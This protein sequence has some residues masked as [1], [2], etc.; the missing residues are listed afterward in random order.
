MTKIFNIAT[1]F[2]LLAF[3]LKT[4]ALESS[5]IMQV[6]ILKAYNKNVLVINRGLEDAI[7]KRDHI[8]MKSSDGFIARG[9]CIKATMLTSHWKIYRVVRPE[10][11]SKDTEYDM[12]SINQSEVPPD[13]IRLTKVDL[14]KYFNSYGDKEANKQLSLQQDRI[15]KYD[16]PKKVSDTD[17][18]SEASK[19][20][21]DRFLERNLDDDRLAKDLGNTYFEIFASPMTWQSR[22][23]QKETHYGAKLYNRGEK[24]LFEIN[25]I[26]TQ[27]EVLDPVTAEGYKSKSTHYSGQFQVNKT[28]E[29][30][31][32]VSNISYD[33]EKIGRI[34]YPHKHLQVGVLGLK[35]HVWEDDP[36]NNFMEIS[37]TPTFDQFEYTDPTDPEL[38]IES[39]SGVRHALRVKIY[40]DI[41]KRLHSKTELS[42]SPYM[43]LEDFGVDYSD[44]NTK[45][46]T[47]LGYEMGSDFYADYILQYDQD[48]FR[49]DTY[50]IR[51]DNTTQ[52]VRLRYEF[53]L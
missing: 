50:D 40:S 33:R 41:T 47:S 11:V 8:K 36:K 52:T 26:E 6:Q 7:F 25:A 13:L 27:R 32:L 51:A 24:Y 46:L 23:N 48:R 31:S 45:V 2:I 4:F 22:Y 19:S 5:D 42:Y 15:A 18:F 38:D 17:T 34:Y 28:S 9:I 35:Y 37:Y 43:L 16:L 44:A 20:N 39:R 29:N 12:Y 14:E 21:L 1:L 53:D 49:A 3:S 30:W 10:L